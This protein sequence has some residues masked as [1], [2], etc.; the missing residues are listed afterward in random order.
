MKTGDTIEWSTKTGTFN[1]N[2]QYEITFSMPQFHK[3]RDITWSVCV[4]MKMK[5]NIP[6]MT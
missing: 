5:K 2:K 3:D 1:T 6:D 4:W